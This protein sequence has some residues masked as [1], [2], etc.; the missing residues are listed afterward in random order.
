MKSKLSLVCLLFSAC[1]FPV[2]A[3]FGLP[4]SV[5]D[6]RSCSETGADLGDGVCLPTQVCSC[7]PGTE[8]SAG[9]CKRRVRLDG[10]AGGGFVSAGGS[11]GLDAGFFAGGSAG[12]F[13]PFDAGF[14]G[15]ST[16]GGFV[17]FD[18]G[19]S[20][21]SAGGSVGGGSV[22]GGGVQPDA[23]LTV[24]CT[25][26]YT[27][28]RPIENLGFE[29]TNRLSV[30]T[31]DS[32]FRSA[33]QLLDFSGTP[34][35]TPQESGHA[36]SGFA[37]RAWNGRDL[38]LLFGGGFGP[39]LEVSYVQSLTSF[40][41]YTRSDLPPTAG[42]AFAAAH[43]PQRDEFALFWNRE[44]F[45]AQQLAMQ[46]RYGDAGVGF[47]NTNV[48]ADSLTS[49]GVVDWAPGRYLLVG[50][51]KLHVINSN[52]SVR[53]TLPL[54]GVGRSVAS[55]GADRAGVVVQGIDGGAL[56]FTAVD[57][58]NGTMTSTDYPILSNIMTTSGDTVWDPVI[59]GWHVAFNETWGPV[60]LATVMPGVGVVS[61]K[62]LAG[63]QA[64][65]Q[66]L[67]AVLQGRS[68]FI[69]YSDYNPV[70]HAVVRIDL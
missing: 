19:F 24:A 63:C 17:P 27:S 46:V 15:G 16:G 66:Q 36:N 59:G 55:N 29:G 60:Q 40:W 68:L 69:S 49:T 38:T 43:D 13:V 23:G 18:A 4:C 53:G 25:T 52:G 3:G 57:G 11:A 48:V 64:R 7:N 61:V 65:G 31:A 30:R 47:T 21:G 10:G 51:Q 56:T 32:A 50:D 54:S 42:G 41:T 12:G 45:P 14:A 5:G 35:A 8:L 22:G 70:E 37:A 1:F 9:R 39:T 33:H 2:D 28:P 6:D 44:T 20:G 26:V 34:L 62:S 58:T 67:K